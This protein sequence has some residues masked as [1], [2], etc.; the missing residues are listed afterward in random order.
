MSTV[1][2]EQQLGLR[3]ERIVLRGE[4]IAFDRLHNKAAIETPRGRFSFTYTESVSVS[5]L[6]DSLST[7]PKENQM[8]R[9]KNLVLLTGEAIYVSDNR[10]LEYVVY[11][12][13]K[14]NP[15]DP[16]YRL[17]EIAQL[18]DDW[19]GEGT[20]APCKEGVEWL[21]DFFC[22]YPKTL[23]PPYMCAWE[24]NT[25]HAEWEQ[26]GSSLILNI[27]ISLDT[28]AAKGVLYHTGDTAVQEVV[29]DFNRPD[30]IERLF[31]VVREYGDEFLN[32]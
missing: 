30:D 24:D 16:I 15:L 3:L 10:L 31:Q 27:D 20:P 1:I 28:H 12:A 14:L 13:E 7:C 22:H 29:Y 5:D 25:I 4:I 32:G 19:D 21:T 8:L 9:K 23:R 26:E 11:S 18:K 17:E 2:S 6:L